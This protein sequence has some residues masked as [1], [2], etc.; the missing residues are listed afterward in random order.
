MDRG[1]RAYG[2]ALAVITMDVVSAFAF[3]AIGVGLN[4]YLDDYCP[5][6]MD[7]PDG[8]RDW[9]SI[10]GQRFANPV[11]IEC[12]FD[13]VGWV[14]QTDPLPLIVA[15]GVVLLGADVAAQPRRSWPS[16]KHQEPA[17]TVDDR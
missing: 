17:T 10:S 5:N 1:G 15:S 2:I 12:R 8:A 13:N 16:A 3:L 14:S 9:K 7:I 4:L 11:T 6:A